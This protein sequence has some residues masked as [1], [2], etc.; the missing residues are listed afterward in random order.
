MDEKMV[1]KKILTKKIGEEMAEDVT[2]SYKFSDN[3]VLQRAVV[4]KTMPIMNKHAFRSFRNGMKHFHKFLGQNIKNT[5]FRGHKFFFSV[6]APQ[7]P[8][9]WRNANIVFVIHVTDLPA[10]WECM[11]YSLSLEK[12]VKNVKNHVIYLLECAEMMNEIISTVF[13]MN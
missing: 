3:S 5:S 12:N 2:E 8:I 1:G 4:K 7:K 13:R 9:F 10:G 11:V 6:F